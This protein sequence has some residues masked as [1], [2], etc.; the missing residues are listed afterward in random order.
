MKNIK[1]LSL[2]FL[3][4]TLISCKKFLDYDPKDDFLIS[5]NVYLKSE[6]DYRTMAVSVYTP[7]QW[8][9]QSVPVGDIA[10]D[11]SVSGGENAS[12]VLP[13][14]QIDDYT[15]TPVNSTLSELWKSAY[16][17][18]N[19]ANYLHQY[20]EKNIAGETINFTG[21]DALY[22]EIYFLRA[23]YYFHLVRF[24]GDAVLFTDKRLGLAESRTL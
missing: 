7:I 6:S 1:I 4:T 14:Q 18:I 19:R 11:N 9:N 5:E 12:D 20:K 16:E 21:K 22:G 10:S 15:L 3:I 2:L 8:L 24:F 23:Y 13:L 17:G